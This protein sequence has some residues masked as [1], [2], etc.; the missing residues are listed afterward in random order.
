[1]RQKTGLVIEIGEWTIPVV[2]NDDGEFW[3]EWEGDS[4]HSTTF[5]G[6]RAKLMPV[7]RVDIKRV[8][9]PA[10]QHWH[11][12]EWEPITL[13]G[14][15]ASN[16]NTLFVNS[17]GETHQ[18]RSFSKHSIFQVLTAAERREH[19]KLYA[20]ERKADRELAEWRK[21]KALKPG[22]VIREKLGLPPEPPKDKSRWSSD[23][24]DDD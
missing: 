20:A 18:V 16:G 23:D 19:A 1:M 2:V 7:A 8:E 11:A 3:C 15:H 9:I 17:K 21:K 5:K 22:R 6:L 4:Y 24:D 12:D 10:L 14:I 13:V